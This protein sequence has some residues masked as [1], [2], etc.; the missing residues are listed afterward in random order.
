MEVS[1]RWLLA[2]LAT[3][4][5]RLS[6]HALIRSDERLVSERDIR[7]CGRTARRVAWQPE[8]ETWKVVGKDEHGDQLTVIC[9]VR[10]GVLVVTV[11]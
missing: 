6:V 9:A 5:F 8:P 11:Y 10:S 3:G 1:K 4:E 7:A 2:R